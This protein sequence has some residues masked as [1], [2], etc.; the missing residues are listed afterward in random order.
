LEKEA[1]KL[2][3]NKRDVWQERRLQNWAK[4]KS[5]I[6]KWTPHVDKIGK[7]EL[8]HTSE[9]QFLFVRLVC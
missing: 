9:D 4:W 6:Y 1:Q 7:Q 2:V 3:N 8:F 5:K